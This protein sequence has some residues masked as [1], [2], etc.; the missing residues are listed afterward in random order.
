[1]HTS[2][3]GLCLLQPIADTMVLSHT[4]S[5]IVETAKKRRLMH[6]LHPTSSLAIYYIFM[7]LKTSSPDGNREGAYYRN[8]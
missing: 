5:L 6:A 3:D 2:R 8:M 4:N 7:S 1:M